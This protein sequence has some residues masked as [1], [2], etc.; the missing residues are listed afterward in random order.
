MTN[1]TPVRGDVAMAGQGLIVPPSLAKP[2]PQLIEALQ[3]LQEDLRLPALQAQIVLDALEL[4]G[5]DS[6][7]LYVPAGDSFRLAALHGRGSQPDFEAVA[8]L[9]ADWPPLRAVM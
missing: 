1:V 6:S 9:P 3:R 5:A 2:V 8:P 7:G 4:A